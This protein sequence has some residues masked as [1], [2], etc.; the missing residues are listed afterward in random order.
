VAEYY[1]L[2]VGYLLTLAISVPAAGFLLRTY[3]V[4]HDC[5]HGSF[6]PTKRGN[7]WLGSRSACSSSR[8]SR[9]GATTTRS[10]TR[11]PVTSTAAGRATCR[12]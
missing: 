10:I 3:I 4:F 12:R 7:L 2:R 9:T 8:R 6:L 1:S 11:R 5:S